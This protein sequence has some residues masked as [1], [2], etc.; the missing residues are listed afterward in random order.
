MM[1]LGM[2]MAILDVQ[3]V[4]TSIPTIERALQVRADQISWIQTAYLIAEVIAIP[5][6][7]VLTRMLSMRWLFV[8]ALSL[9]TASSAGC[10][11]SGSF[12]SLIPPGAC[13]GWGFPAEP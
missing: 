1:C 10:A 7:G 8:G 11:A 3:V 2:F 6:T 9:P 4:A 13:C 12:A 5:L